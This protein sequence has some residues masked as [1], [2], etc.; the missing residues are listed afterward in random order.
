MWIKKHWI[1]VRTSPPLTLSLSPGISMVEN[2][3]GKN[4]RNKA[5]SCPVVYI[6]VLTNMARHYFNSAV[7]LSRSPSLDMDI[8]GFLA[9][10]SKVI[11]LIELIN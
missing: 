11:E 9:D 3:K 5:P 8:S 2:L 6:L 10:S 7:S 4:A 1:L